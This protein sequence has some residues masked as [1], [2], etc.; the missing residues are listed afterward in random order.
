M[1]QGMAS[2][3]SEGDPRRATLLA[4]AEEH[5]A[6]GRGDE[7]DPMP[8]RGSLGEGAAGEQRLVIRVRM[9]G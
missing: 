5:A 2:A 3:L 4:L 7:D 1:L 9:E 8:R 6:V